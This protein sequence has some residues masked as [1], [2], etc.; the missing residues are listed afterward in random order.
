MRIYSEYG[1]C[2]DFDQWA[3]LKHSNQIWFNAL[4]QIMVALM[5]LK[6]YFN[7]LHVDFH[8]KNIIVQK[9]KPGGYWEYKIDGLK[10][11]VPNLGFVFLI[12]DFGFS[13]IP[14]KLTIPWLYK[15]TLKY[16]TKTGEQFYDIFSFYENILEDKSYKLPK[17]FKSQI[18]KLFTKQEFYIYTTKY[19]KDKIKHY[20][21][22]PKKQK[23]FKNILNKYPANINNNYRALNTTLGDKIYTMF[24]KHNFHDGTDVFNM[25]EII[26]SNKLPQNTELIDSFSVDKSLNKEKF[27]D[28][29]Q[30]LIT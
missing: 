30:H 15:S 13:W 16:I 23:V 21:D 27:P 7:M 6:R 1:N 18:K 2:Q 8:T 12:T 28:S 26:Y 3:T 25:Q 14:D 29:F 22:K 20:Q 10:Y 4:F 5:S 11:N 24:Y 9:I 17:Y 19:Y